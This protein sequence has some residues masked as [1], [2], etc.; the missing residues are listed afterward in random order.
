MATGS[1]LG[2]F[3]VLMIVFLGLW[4][5][6]HYTGYFWSEENMEKR[7]R[8]MVER[9]VP[10]VESYRREHGHL[11]DTLNLEGFANDWGENSYID[12][13]G[14]DYLGF[15]YHKW[16]DSTYVLV[17]KNEWA[18]YVSSPKFEGYYFFRWDEDGDSMRIDTLF[19]QHKK[20]NEH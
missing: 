20:K 18:K 17:H 3:P 8:E 14:W 6:V 5:D 11:P 13:S 1:M 4:W 12:T 16:D 2:L 19:I 15:I 9:V 7:F 10:Q